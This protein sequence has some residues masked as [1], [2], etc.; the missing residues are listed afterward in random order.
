[1]RTA[2]ARKGQRRHRQNQNQHCQR[3]RRRRGCQHSPEIAQ[4]DARGMRP[5][6]SVL[7]RQIRQG[8]TEPVLRCRVLQRRSGAQHRGLGRG[9]HRA[10]IRTD[11][12]DESPGTLLPQPPPAA[13]LPRREGGR[14]HCRDGVERPRSRLARGSAGRNGHAGRPEG[15]GEGRGGRFGDVRYGRRK[16]VQ[17]RQGVQGQQAVQRPVRAG[18]ATSDGCGG[19]FQHQ[20]QQLHAGTYRGDGS[21][22]GSE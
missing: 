8:P 2:N 3:Q 21:V 10:G 17:R 5:R 11:R 13:I 6:G 4:I 7:H 15:V 22:P 18:V 19:G 14:P 9:A 1:M 12:R 20:G 16:R